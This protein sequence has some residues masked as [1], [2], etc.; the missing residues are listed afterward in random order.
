MISTSKNIIFLY[1]LLTCG[2]VN[3]NTTKENYVNR[4]FET[5]N[6]TDIEAISVHNSID[7]GYL[8]IFVAKNNDKIVGI[9]RIDRVAKR[10]VT[11]PE[12]RYVFWNKGKSMADKPDIVIYN[13]TLEERG[14]AHNL[15]YQFNNNGYTYMF[16]DLRGCYSEEDGRFHLYVEKENTPLCGYDVDI[17]RIADNRIKNACS[18]LY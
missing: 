10:D 13:G 8:Y 6:T 11:P 9:G 5:V 14:T 2:C 15:F 1:L 7:C 4:L 17:I 18:V 12:F 16:D 3:T